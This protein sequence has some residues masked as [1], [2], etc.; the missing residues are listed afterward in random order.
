MPISRSVTSAPPSFLLDQKMINTHLFSS[1][2]EFASI[3]TGRIAIDRNIRFPVMSHLASAFAG[4]AALG[5]ADVD[6]GL[7]GRC[8][9]RQ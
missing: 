4:G 7:S 5:F 2:P 6:V 9:E 3:P 1:I 8:L